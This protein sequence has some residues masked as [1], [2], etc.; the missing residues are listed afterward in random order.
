MDEL[1]S[2][3]LPHSLEAEQ[4]VLGAILID[5]RCL[6]EVIEQ[7]RPQD[8]FL[9]Q[10]REVYEAVRPRFCL[11]CTPTWLWDNMGPNGYDTGH[12]QTVVVRGWMSS[13]GCVERHY[14]MMDGDQIIDL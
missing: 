6:P 5:A 14:R 13:L 12:Y 8:F 7:L 2:H 4:A 11:W 1:L 3:Q 10:N 9:R